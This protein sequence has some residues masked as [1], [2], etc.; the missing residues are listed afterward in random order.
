MG[1]PIPTASVG[2]IGPYPE[3]P[4]PPSDSRQFPGDGTKPSG[5]PTTSWHPFALPRYTNHKGVPG[6]AERVREVPAVGE[7]PN[8]LPGDD[9]WVIE[10][11]G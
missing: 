5:T 3:H 6:N 4:E 9:D 2:Q 7:W 11:L 1:K 8:P 10:G